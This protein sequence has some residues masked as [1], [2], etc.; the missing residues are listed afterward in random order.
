[1][2]IHRISNNLFLADLDIP[3]P[4]FYNFISSWIL[5]EGNRA[6]VI[7]PGP[8]TTV[9][10]LFSSLKELEVEDID[11]ILLTHIHL[12]HAGGCGALAKSYPGS[13]I[14]CHSRAMKHLENPQRLWEGSLKVLGDL[15]E[16]YGRPEPVD[17]QRLYPE[18][19]ILWNDNL[20][21][22]LD[23]PGHAPHHLA[24]LLGDIL[25]AGE[26]SGARLPSKGG[27]YIRPATPPPFR[28]EIA[29]DSLSLAIK[30]KPKQICYGHYG[31]VNQAVK[32]MKKSKDQL[33]L[34]LTLLE[35]KFKTDP[36][37]DEDRAMKLL[38]EKD[39]HL[40]F[41]YDLEPDVREREAYFIK[42]SIRGMLQYLQTVE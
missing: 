10:T 38:L 2:A 8:S 4:G 24:F 41:Y 14:V 1:M 15:A 22:S 6:I 42:N 17:G 19:D 32:M 27:L 25:F 12:D 11:Y 26:V 28:P 20:I 36:E 35:K 29:L 3:R 21:Q 33:N 5:K 13:F 31:I 34:W 40:N 18:G 37:L 7:D 16:S 30:A 9:E 39:P 23:T